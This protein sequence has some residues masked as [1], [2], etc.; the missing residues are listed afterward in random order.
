MTAP[1]RDGR[2]DDE[3]RAW[4]RRQPELHS[5]REGMAL[6]DFDMVLHRYKTHQDKIGTRDI[7]CMMLLEYKRYAAPLPP[8][9]RDTLGIFHQMFDR[10]MRKRVKSPMTGGMVLVNYYGVHVLRM[11]GGTPHTSEWIEWDRRRIDINKLFLLM[12]MDLSPFFP[13][14]PI[15]HRRHHRVGR[16]GYHRRLPCFDD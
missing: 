8:S 12:R 6:S 15:T 1:R 14:R 7:Q 13:F 3:F 10:R 9:Q 16:D 2:D 11:S 4:C 5:V